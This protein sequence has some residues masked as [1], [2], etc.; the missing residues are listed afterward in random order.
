MALNSNKIK[1]GNG[2]A[3]RIE[4]P[5]IEPGMYP[6]R[7]VQVIDLGLQAQRPYQGQEKPPANEIMLTYELVDTFC[8][9]KDGNEDE[10][11]PRWIS[12]NIPLYNIKQDKAKSTQRYLAVDPENINDGDFSKIVDVPINVAVVHNKKGD[13]T[14]VNVGGISSMRGRDAAKC[15]EL[16]NPA[17]VFDLDE[18]DMEIFN[19]LPDWIKEKVKQNLNFQGS[20]LQQALGGKP[21]PAEKEKV[22]EPDD[23][24]ED[25]DA[26][27]DNAAPWD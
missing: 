6:G 23:V 19:S 3:D 5:L 8:V 4:Q 12:E 11:K 2:N 26:V 22:P 21:A 7:I 24:V 27:D 25:D 13:K 14:Y 10:E 15:A 18:P 16:K 1:G 17:K 20:P 9:D